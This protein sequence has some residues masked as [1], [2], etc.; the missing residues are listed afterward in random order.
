MKKN[1]SFNTSKY[2][3]I[4]VVAVTSLIMIKCKPAT[5]K[6]IAANHALSTDTKLVS[7]SQ[8]PLP[9]APG[10]DA[11]RMNCMICHSERYVQMQPEF[12]RQTWEKIVDKM[13]K[14]YGAP[15][16]DSTEKNIV[17]YLITIRGKK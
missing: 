10:A 11:F 1:L 4:F 5:E 13:I 15:I 14:S 8:T 3:M 9:E 6:N 2:K 16:P 12:S 17:D 7:V